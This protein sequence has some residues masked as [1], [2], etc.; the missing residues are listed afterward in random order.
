MN[1]FTAV[2]KNNFRI[3]KFETRFRMDQH[4]L[5]AENLKIMTSGSSVD[6][7]VNLNYSST[8][9][10]KDSMGTMVLDMNMK[11]LRLVN[12]DLTYFS[13][14]LKENAFFKNGENVTTFSGQ[15]KGPVNDLTGNNIVVRTG[16]NTS[17]STQISI[18][19]LPEIESSFFN[20]E[21]L[22]INTNKKD[23]LMFAGSGPSS[24]EFPDEVAVS[25][26]F[27]GTLRAFKTAIAVNSSYGDADVS[28]SI[29]R[30]E[31]FNGNIKINDFDLASLLRNDSVFG[32]LS[33]VA[34]LKGHGLDKEKI[35]ATVKAEFPEIVLN[36]YS[37][38]NLNLEGNITGREFNGNINLNDE[39][40]AF[41]LNA[42]INL[43]P[44]EE[45][46][47]LNLDLTGAD[48]QKL[49]LV[50]DDIR[51]GLKVNTDLSGKSLRD[52][53]GKILLSNILIIKEKEKSNLDSIV[54]S[55]MNE[56]GKTELNLRS[57]LA[58]FDYNGTID[59][60]ELTRFPVSLINKY[61]PFSDTVNNEEFNNDQ[62]FDFRIDAA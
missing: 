4:S 39:N 37:Y 12:S 16:A 13:P 18:K 11:N 50:K 62:N 53:N 7:D 52:L 25:A 22:N 19:G 40:A 8:E 23:L 47:K 31:N 3:D 57:Q 46:Y 10:I 28:F 59:L 15:L 21:D 38:H 45:H 17:V 30:N 35:I 36:K 43:K 20:I 56:E 42:L 32:H 41:D 27:K 49:N 9:A 34:E 33:L 29:D 5:S 58:D 26:S 2:D 24:V 54:F 14:A 1:K 44:G 60:A 6:A 55:I 48:L 61:F 51:I